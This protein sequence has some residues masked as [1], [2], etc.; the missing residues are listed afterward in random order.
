MES[1]LGGSLGILVFLFLLVLAILWFCLPIAVFGTKDILSKIVKQTEKTNLLLET[2]NNN[3]VNLNSDVAKNIEQGFSLNAEKSSANEFVVQD[4]KWN[5]AKI[6]VPDVKESL[7][8]L[9]SEFETLP[10]HKD[11]AE[12]ALKAIFIHFGVNGI[13]QKMLD[14]IIEQVNAH[15][16]KLQEEQDKELARKEAEERKREAEKRKRVEEEELRLLEK[17]RKQAE[18]PKSSRSEAARRRR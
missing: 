16:S 18:E 17:A 12:K 5:I 1:L 9:S 6:Y 7:S 14:N 11:E 2:L 3:I 4:T 15:Q 10:S 8:Y 13:N